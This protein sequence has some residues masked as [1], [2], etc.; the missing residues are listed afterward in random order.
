MTT[1]RR[2]DSEKEEKIK[3][4]DCPKRVAIT[5]SDSGTFDESMVMKSAIKVGT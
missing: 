1:M 5:K 3:V 4:V 2:R